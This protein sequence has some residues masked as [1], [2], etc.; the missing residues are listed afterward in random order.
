MKKRNKYLFPIAHALWWI[1]MMGGFW[2]IVLLSFPFKFVL[3]K[4][5]FAMTFLLTIFYGTSEF[6]V[7]RYF[8]KQKYG[9]FALSVLLMLIPIVLIRYFLEEVWLLNMIGKSR[10]DEMGEGVKFLS[11]IPW[12]RVTYTSITFFLLGFFYKLVYREIIRQN[13][14]NELLALQ[15]ETELKQLQHQINPHFLFNTLNNIYTLALVKDN[16]TAPMLMKLSSML[17]TSLYQS[18]KER[19]SLFKEIELINNFLDL[20]SLKYMP[21]P[22]GKLSAERDV[23]V[24]PL[25]FLPVIENM[26]KHGDPE[27]AEG[28]ELHIHLTEH[29]LHFHA[30]NPISS[31]PNYEGEGS[32][33]GLENVKKR[34]DLLFG[35]KHAFDQKEL[36]ENFRLEISFPVE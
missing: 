33:I 4:N 16:Q 18:D 13:R 28:W 6:L 11:T 19:I 32:G 24:P 20:Y 25:I 26:F 22:V 30:Q 3:W 14:K 31:M 1:L 10:L 35:N 15:Y 23:A 29:E 8:E 12:L 9:L 7:P 27:K 17:R 5:F 2:G 36:G 34:L 21:M